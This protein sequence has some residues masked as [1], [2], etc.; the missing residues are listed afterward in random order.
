[1]LISL[2]DSAPSSFQISV[3]ITQES[4]YSLLDHI[5][6]RSFWALSSTR[7]QQRP[8]S[9]LWSVQPNLSK[10]LPNLYVSLKF[11]S[12]D[13]SAL[14][15][16]HTLLASFAEVSQCPTVAIS[17]KVFCAVSSSIR[18]TCPLAVNALT[19]FFMYFSSL[20]GWGWESEPEASS[21]IV[22]G[23]DSPKVPPS[24]WGRFSCNQSLISSMKNP[25]ENYQTLF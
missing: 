8:L 11:P 15:F 14:V 21:Y 6:G 4:W 25:T 23:Q 3:S 5:W 9:C 18:I 16:G 19:Q 13:S 22:T 10:H 1:M 2:K 24:C 7:L 12:V 20:Y 17:M